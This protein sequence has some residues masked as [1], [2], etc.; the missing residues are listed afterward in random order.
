MK[1]I[2]LLFFMFANFLQG[3][4]VVN[5]FTQKTPL[6]VLPDILIKKDTILITNQNQ[7][8]FTTIG[9]HSPAYL[10]KDMKDYRE[11]LR[12]YKSFFYIVEGELKGY[13]LIK[14]TISK[15]GC[16]HFNFVSSFDKSAEMM[17]KDIVLGM[18]GWIPAMNEKGET[19]EAEGC[20]VALFDVEPKKYYI[21]H[22]I[23][24]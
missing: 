8:T 22:H 17:M 2:L 24:K 3:Q 4:T 1:I 7:G 15:E 18:K 14:F 6:V 9:A 16:I 23:D 11:Y 20:L 21:K 19:I 10:F 5:N 13:V 12:K